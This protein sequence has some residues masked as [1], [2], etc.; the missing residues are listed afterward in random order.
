MSSPSPELSCSQPIEHG[1]AIEVHSPLCVDVDMPIHT[2]PVPFPLPGT[3]NFRAAVRRAAILDDFSSHHATRQH[4]LLAGRAASNTSFNTDVST[5]P[6]SNLT[7]PKTH[8]GPSRLIGQPTPQTNGDSDTS[9]FSWPE[10]TS[11]L[12]A[13]LTPSKFMATS[14]SMN[15]TMSPTFGGRGLFMAPTA[16]AACALST[17]VVLSAAATA[18]DDGHVVTMATREPSMMIGPSTSSL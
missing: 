8:V 17:T 6:I 7:S 4:R 9:S 12:T 15:L 18:S 2:A 13:A 1:R 14:S 5:S 3:P 16:T 11:D 10:V